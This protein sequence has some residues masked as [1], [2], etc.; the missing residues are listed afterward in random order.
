[1]VQLEW[2]PSPNIL[3]PVQTWK[4]RSKMVFQIYNCL[5]TFLFGFDKAVESLPAMAK[6]HLVAVLLIMQLSG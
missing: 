5:G 2:H 6:V 4:K 1:M 3:L